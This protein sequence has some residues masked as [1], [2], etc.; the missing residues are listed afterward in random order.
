MAKQAVYLSN[1]PNLSTWWGT[2]TDLE[3]ALITKKGMASKWFYHH[4]T[5]DDWGNFL[6]T[7]D[8]KVSSEHITEEE[9]LNLIWEKVKSFPVRESQRGNG[10]NAG[11]SARGSKKLELRFGVTGEPK[12][13]DKQARLDK[14]KSMKADAEELGVGF[15]YQSE[16]DKLEAE[17]KAWNTKYN[18][19]LNLDKARSANSYDYLLKVSSIMAG[20]QKAVSQVVDLSA[21]LDNFVDNVIEPLKSGNAEDK[22]N[23]KKYEH[24]IGVY[25][26]FIE[27]SKAMQKVIDNI[28]NPMTLDFGTHKEESNTDLEAELENGEADNK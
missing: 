19:Q 5:T 15:A 12:P 24:A 2:R 26:K 25:R 22:D 11:T 14:F 1:Y 3:Q 7:V 13:F 27:A 20:E 6:G 9:A 18:S 10:T 17:K 16:I 23:A 28:E 4:E 8:K 21:S